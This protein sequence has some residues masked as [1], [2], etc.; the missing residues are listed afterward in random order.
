MFEQVSSLHGID[1][2]PVDYSQPTIAN[3]AGLKPGSRR[4]V[5]HYAQRL[6]LLVVEGVLRGGR[7]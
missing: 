7:C 2:L 1:A 4:C 3:Y 6:V 5:E